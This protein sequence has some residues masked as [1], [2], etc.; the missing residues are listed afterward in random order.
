MS[1]SIRTKSP[2]KTV[3]QPIAL[4][5]EAGAES[6]C[7]SIGNSDV[8]KCSSRLFRFPVRSPEKIHEF[9]LQTGV[10]LSGATRPDSEELFD[11]PGHRT[12]YLVSVVNLGSS[13]NPLPTPQK[14]HE[15]SLQ[16]G[17]LWTGDTKPDSEE[18]F[19]CPGHRTAYQVSVVNLASSPEA[20][21]T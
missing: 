5:A 11:C 6:L 14:I 19:D 10:S 18:L 21:P 20:V 13:T 8:R 4:F 9:S 3:R 17:V 1:A 12:A 2:I 15:F 16:T 7:T